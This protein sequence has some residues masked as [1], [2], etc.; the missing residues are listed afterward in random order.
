MLDSK[1]ITPPYFVRFLID[2]QQSITEADQRPHIHSYTCKWIKISVTAMLGSRETAWIEKGAQTV[3]GP[4]DVDASQEKDQQKRGP[5]LTGSHG[6][7]T[8]FDVIVTGNGP[9]NLFGKMK[10]G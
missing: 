6:A 10:K 1:D 3:D 8:E 9:Y 2:P 5:E 7:D 4:V